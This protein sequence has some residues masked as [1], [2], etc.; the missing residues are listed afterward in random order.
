MDTSL[1]SP[2]PLGASWRVL[3]SWRDLLA[4]WRKRLA[5]AH[6]PLHTIPT[7]GVVAAYKPCRRMRG[8]PATTPITTGPT[9]F[10][11]LTQRNFGQAR[12]VKRVWHRLRFSLG[13]AV[14]SQGRLPPAG[15]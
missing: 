2:S 12:G 13:S 1:L 14:G 11:E 3:A 5:K 9:R 8:E 15:G 4:S 10:F 6:A 7:I